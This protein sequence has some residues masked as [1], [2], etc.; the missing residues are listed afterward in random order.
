[1]K[2]KLPFKRISVTLQKPTKND[3]WSLE[4]KSILS[5]LPGKSNLL[6]AYFSLVLALQKALEASSEMSNSLL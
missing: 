4:Q 3:V 2:S 5:H 6:N 1:M